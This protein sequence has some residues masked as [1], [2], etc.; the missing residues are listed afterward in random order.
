MWGLI[1]LLAVS[2]MGP[3]APPDPAVVAATRLVTAEQ[4]ES[5][6]NAWGWYAAG[7]AYDVG[8]TAL[9]FARHDGA[10]EANPIFG[11]RPLLVGGVKLALGVGAWR[12][13]VHWT[14][15]GHPERAAIMRWVYVVVSAVAGT[16]NLSLAF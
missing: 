8:S 13:G 5:A 2:P 16:W 7:W 9:V 10:A 6:R 14:D 1:A 3:P 4:R 11:D 12:L 15:A